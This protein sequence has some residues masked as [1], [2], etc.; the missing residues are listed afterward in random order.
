[1]DWNDVGLWPLGWFAVAIIT[2]GLA[3][4]KGRSRWYWF[5]WALL[6]GPIA[7]TLVVVW[8]RPQRAAATPADADRGSNS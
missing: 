6:F 5:V 1:M 4:T 7:T 8:P 2:A 3:E